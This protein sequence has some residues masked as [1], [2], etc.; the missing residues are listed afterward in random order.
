MRA[1]PSTDSLTDDEKRR[2]AL[3][4]YMERWTTRL[5]IRALMR[6]RAIKD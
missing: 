6:R 1:D 2:R 5:M 3:A 4:D